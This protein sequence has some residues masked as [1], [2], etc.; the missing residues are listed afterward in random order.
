MHPRDVAVVQ[1][2][3]LAFFLHVSENSQILAAPREKYEV[4]KRALL[5]SVFNTLGG[6]H[7]FSGEKQQ[8]KWQTIKF[9]SPP[10]LNF[11]GKH[12]ELSAVTNSV[13]RI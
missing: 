8:R 13:C 4:L 1:N 9:P 10:T 2:I 6:D 7:N 11:P 3:S 5:E 12:L